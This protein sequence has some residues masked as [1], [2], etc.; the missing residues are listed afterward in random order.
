[1]RNATAVS[2]TAEPGHRLRFKG[3]R[4]SPE[5]RWSPAGEASRQ[6]RS[7]KFKPAPNA[8][9]SKIDVYR[10]KQGS[11]DILELTDLNLVLADIQRWERE[12]RIQRL[13]LAGRISLGLAAVFLVVMGTLLLLERVGVSLPSWVPFVNAE[14]Q[15]V[16]SLTMGSWERGFLLEA[17]QDAVADSGNV[18]QV[19]SK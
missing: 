17:C 4:L 2:V 11:E 10:E 8:P 19:C 13:K 12:I 5:L 16:S 1:L 18:S 7:I 15:D 6:E 14:I 3:S 9:R